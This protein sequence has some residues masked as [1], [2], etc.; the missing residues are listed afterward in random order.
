MSSKGVLAQNNFTGGEVSP[1]IYGRVDLSRYYNSLARCRNFIVRPEGG[2]ENR[3]GF[4]FCSLALPGSRLIP[5][6]FSASQSRMLV[7]TPKP[8][9]RVMR[10][11]SNGSLVLT[12]TDN[13]T[14]I[15]QS[16]DSTITVN[17]S[18]T[19]GDVVFISGVN[20]MLEINNNLYE[21]VAASGT[22]IK[23]EPLTGPVN[24]PGPGMDT[25]GFGAYTSG[26]T[27]GKVYELT[28]PY[29]ADELRDVK[30]EQSADT[31]FLTHPN[32]QT[33]VLRRVADNNWTLDLYEVG[34]SIEAPAAPTLSYSG[35]IGLGTS[36][37]ER[38]KVSALDSGDGEGP[39][40]PPSFVLREDP[41]PANEIVTVTWSSV[42]GASAYNIYKEVAAFSETFRFIGR[43]TTN[44]FLDVNIVPDTNKGPAQSRKPFASN[45]HPA[46]SA[47]YEE[48]LMFAAP[49][50]NPQTVYGSQ[51]GDYFNFDT[52]TPLRD[53]DGVEFTI[54]ARQVNQIRW[55]VSLKELLLLTSGAVWSATGGGQNSPLTPASIRVNVQ[56]YR[57]VAD[58]QP[59]VSGDSVIY[60]QDKGQAVRD[61][62]YSI[63]EDVYSGSDLSI[64]A[65]HLFDGFTIVS[66]AYTEAPVPIMWFVRS[67]G[68][69]LSLTYMREQEVWG[70]ALHETD[71]NVQWVSS[72]GE[73][74]RDVLYAIIERPFGHTVERLS[75]RLLCNSDYQLGMFSDSAARYNGSPVSTLYGL[76]H[77]RN[78]SVIVLAD[79]FVVRGKT[80]DGSGRLQLDAPA[81]KV[82]VGLPYESL[83]ETLM[84]AQGGDATLHTRKRIA[85]RAWMRFAKARGVEIAQRD[86]MPFQPIR[87]R[88]TQGFGQAVEPY[89]G[90]YQYDINSSWQGEFEGNY[91]SVVI[92]QREPLPA[93]ILSLYTEWEVG[94]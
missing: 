5:F 3:P 21:V 38:Y 15:T 82:V 9:S 71:G 19:I 74:N 60:V 10:V 89:S 67:D 37:T 27:V 16:T 69:L 86:D 87:E 39:P 59:I 35:T 36:R 41:W 84:Q 92:R 78:R 51:S 94:G 57:G 65:K 83:A 17:N 70:W 63:A 72:I 13:I 12:G 76:W 52:Q 14:G 62:F 50:A 18:L 80:V 6:Q 29:T 91:G 66:T 26:G 32:H 20:G 56:E 68:K 46:V 44:T 30:F 23:V 42:S 2:I 54:A 4:E 47:F 90:V 61:L 58:V 28:L 79:G 49:T 7:F 22:T 40:S 31:M 75:C 81:S 77:L 34:V 93:T 85:K 24:V 1:A 48:R 11:L 45:N 53:S 25:S 55:M 88:T 8:A 73:D 43:S 64:L 33:R